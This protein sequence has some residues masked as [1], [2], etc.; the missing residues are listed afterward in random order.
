MC[1]CS[2]TS[3]SLW[4]HGLQPTRLLSPWD[5]PGKNTGM[6]CHVLLWGIFWTQGSNLHLL[7][8]LHWQVGSLPLVLPTPHVGCGIYTLDDITH[9]MDMNLRKLRSCW[10]IGKRGMLQSTG[11]Q[12]VGHD[13]PTEQQQIPHLLYSFICW[14]T[15]RL[16]PYPGYC[17]QCC[18]EHL[19]GMYLLE[20]W[21]SPD[22]NALEWDCC[23]IH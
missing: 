2:V 18:S 5:S 21:F 3:D 23:I 10:W 14:W 4:P 7:C 20:L 6:G 12:R 8:L 9:S 15:F 22:I 13:R 1:A 16:L 19:G 17:K 11:S